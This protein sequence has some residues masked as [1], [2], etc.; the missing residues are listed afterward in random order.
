MASFS[1]FICWRSPA[2]CF[3]GSSVIVVIFSCLSC[4]VSSSLSTSFP[5]MFCFKNSSIIVLLSRFVCSGSAPAS[6][7][8]PSVV[9]VTMLSCFSC[10]ICSSFAISSFLR[11]H[12]LGRRLGSPEVLSV[13]PARISFNRAST[14]S[15]SGS[16]ICLLV[17]SFS[18]WA[19]A[20]CFNLS[21][22]A[23]NRSRSAFFF[24]MISRCLFS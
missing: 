2:V 22:S 23:F 12:L 4:F 6:C 15:S 18:C 10:F 16:G 17:T 24:S 1:S 14:M 19:F 21:F 20:S 3:P 5:F 13:V 7:F 8:K 11:T 9:I